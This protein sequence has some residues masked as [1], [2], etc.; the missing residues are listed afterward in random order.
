MAKT[1]TMRTLWTVV[2]Y[3]VNQGKIVKKHTS[4]VYTNGEQSESDDCFSFPFNRLCVDLSFGVWER[5]SFS[6]HPHDVKCNRSPPECLPLTSITTY[7]LLFRD[8]GGV[9]RRDKGVQQRETS[10][11]FNF[12]GSYGRCTKQLIHY[13]VLFSLLSQIS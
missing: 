9:S 7:P 11:K 4:L 3:V 10:R 6:G 12:P 13:P 2:K 5:L 1:K 8:G